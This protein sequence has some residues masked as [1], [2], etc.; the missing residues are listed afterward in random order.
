M[1]F[2]VVVVVI[3]DY[4]IKQKCTV[5]YWCYIAYKIGNEWA[6]KIGSAFMLSADSQILS[7]V[8]H[9]YAIWS[10]QFYWIL[11]FSFTGEGS[12]ANSFAILSHTSDYKSNMCPFK[13]S[14]VLN[15]HQMSFSMRQL[16]LRLDKEQ[17]SWSCK[18][19]YYCIGWKQAAVKEAP[20]GFFPGVRQARSSS[21][22][23]QAI[24]LDFDIIPWL[25]TSH[26]IFYLLIVK[27][28]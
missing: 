7:L 22:S 26:L 8:F 14:C 13:C 15:E 10:L 11:L 23:E 1:V 25:K 5:L 20:A 18:H 24:N 27:D 12:K 28:Y 16:S 4:L 6:L 3:L 19:W 9:S 17:E 2:V 21:F